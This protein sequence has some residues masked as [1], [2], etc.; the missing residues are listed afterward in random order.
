MQYP[1]EDI[2]TRPARTGKHQKNNRLAMPVSNQGVLFH[3]AL[4]VSVF[5]KKDQPQNNK[6]WRKCRKCLVLDCMFALVPG[7]T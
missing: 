3:P 2:C 6:R 7:R 5:D 1:W 4:S